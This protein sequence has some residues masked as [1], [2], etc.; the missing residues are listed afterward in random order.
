MQFNKNKTEPFHR[1]LAF[2]SSK[3]QTAI[4]ILE[5]VFGKRREQYCWLLGKSVQKAL[6]IFS[7]GAFGVEAP[8]ALMFFLTEPVGVV[9]I[10]IPMRLPV[11]CLIF[12]CGHN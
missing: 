12:V 6:F 7:G 3:F 2:E 4:H 5:I 11:R 10:C 9:K 1:S 8:F